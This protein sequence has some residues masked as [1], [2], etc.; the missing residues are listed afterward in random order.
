MSKKILYLHREILVEE[1]P[2]YNMKFSPYHKYNV[3]T[4]FTIKNI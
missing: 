3:P 1:C 2:I 4:F